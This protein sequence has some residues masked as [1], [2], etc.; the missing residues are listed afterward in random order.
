LNAKI[1]R[2][3]RNKN[4][5]TNTNKLQLLLAIFLIHND[6]F[7]GWLLL[8]QFADNNG[9]SSKM[10][11][12]CLLPRSIDVRIEKAPLDAVGESWF[13]PPPVFFYQQAE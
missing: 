4:N 6:T 8:H 5:Q 2:E 13:L 7:V 1:G 3:S 11:A 12:P 9:S 10:F